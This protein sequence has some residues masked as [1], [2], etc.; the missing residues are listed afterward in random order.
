MLHHI[1]F[2]KIGTP[3]ATCGGSA[4]RFY[5]E[6]EERLALRLPAGYGYANRA[7]DRWYLLYMLMNHKPTRLDGYVRYTVSYATGTKLT[8]VKPIWLDVRNCKG[9]DPSYD[10]PGTGKR[11][12]THTERFSW[13]SPESGRI[14]AGGGH[15]HGGGVRLDLVNA[16]CG[17][18]L[19]SS[20]PTWGGPV[21]R[22]ILHEPGPTRMSQ[23]RSDAGIPVAA[24]QTLEL[25]SV[26]DNGRPHTRA[27]GIMI[28]YLASSAVSGCQGVPELDVD[29]GRPSYPPVFSFPLPRAPSGPVAR[30][31]RS[32][33][34][35]DF[36]YQYERVSLRRGTT[37]TWTFIGSTQHDVTLVRGP[38]GFS[39]PWTLAGTYSRTFTKRGTYEFFCSLHPAQMTQKIV[40]R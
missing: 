40:V 14:V 32:S 28:L 13:T 8:P 12:S 20:R 9:A 11:F 10:V 19:F 6:G 3:D 1:V 34:V 39:T 23:F 15:L 30:D 37:F 26:Y 18:Q 25:R 36:R 2:G 38:V 31:V 27:M 33:W 7:T 24:G 5:A 29:L 17:T 16:T 4:E 21:P 35:G 22:P